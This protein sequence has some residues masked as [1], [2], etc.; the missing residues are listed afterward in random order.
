MGMGVTFDRKENRALRGHSRVT[1]ALA[2]VEFRGH[3]GRVNAF[4]SASVPT[5]LLQVGVLSPILVCRYLPP[6]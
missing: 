5:H 3:T 2:H 4:E 1:H 6:G